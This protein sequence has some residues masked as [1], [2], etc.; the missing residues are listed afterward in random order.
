MIFSFKGLV[1]DTGEGEYFNL[2]Y[3]VEDMVDEYYLPTMLVVPRP[4][5]PNPDPMPL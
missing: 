3:E 2:L 4:V 1:I 5:P